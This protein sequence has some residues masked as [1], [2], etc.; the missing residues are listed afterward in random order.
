MR[1]GTVLRAKIYR[2]T[3]ERRRPVLLYRTP[4]AKERVTKECDSDSAVRRGYIVVAQDLHGCGRS[5][6]E[7]VPFA[8]DANDGADTVAW[9]AALPNADGQVEMF[10]QSS[11]AQD[12][13]LVEGRKPAAWKAMV[14]WLCPRDC[15]DRHG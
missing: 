15:F 8:D 13:W 7:S 5:K 14:P 2:P 4:D 9:V 6:G 10:G 3:G 1:D 12:Q 11:T